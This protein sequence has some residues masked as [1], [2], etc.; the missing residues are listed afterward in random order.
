[1]RYVDDYTHRFGAEGVEEAARAFDRQ[2][3]AAERNA[4]RLRAWGELAQAM[5]PRIEA[6]G[7]RGL[8]AAR[9]WLG[10]AG[11]M[12]QA[13]VAFTTLLGSG[14][15]A[16]KFVSQLQ[17][18]AA[19]TPFEFRGLQQ[20]AKR[21]LAQGFG[22]EEIIPMLTDLGDAAGALGAG[23]EG[24]DRLV[25]A[26][27]QMRAMGKP[28]GD[29]LRQIAQLGIPAQKILRDAFNIPPGKNVADAAI[30]AEQ[31]IGAIRRY[32]REHYGGGMEAQSKTLA[33][34]LSNLADQADLLKNTLGEPLVG[35]VNAATQATERMLEGL[36]GM[37]SEARAA[38]GWTT[39]LGGAAL[40]AG[41]GV[42]SAWRDL[43]Q[44]RAILQLTNISK[45]QL[46]AATGKDIAAERAK[47]GVARGEAA[48]ISEVEKA[49]VGATQA[50]L[51]LAGA[52][53]KGLTGGLGWGGL[54]TAPAGAALT[55]GAGLGAAAA[56]TSIISA[57][58]AG[59]IGWEIGK[60]VSDWLESYK[61]FIDRET[62]EKV[63]Y[64]EAAGDW[65]E[66]NLPMGRLETGAEI[67]ERAG[68]AVTGSEIAAGFAAMTP[69]QKAR[70]ARELAAKTA[71]LPGGDLQ[72]TVTVPGQ[73]VVTQQALANH[74]ALR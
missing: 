65:L 46:A 13:R 38:V 33:G 54:M 24:I 14:D 51:R 22:V 15:Q 41:G 73:Q 29:D 32:M 53:G 37:S 44:Y 25:L 64:K 23:A 43:R 47:A 17:E 3:D 26:F 31:A 5:G 19:R 55:G 56:A 39:M 40:K 36:R 67:R 48:A 8:S 71:V 62:G 10:M 11:E 66:R 30:T 70:R 58:A 12:E 63:G 28:M 68:K 9:S 4:A 35:S 69:E 49:A 42:L 72:V 60:A 6:L 61:V 27:G 18:F 1:M 21:L 74:A 16:A 45:Q 2:G 50:K 52:T 20:Q 59:I 34:S 57:A 7:D